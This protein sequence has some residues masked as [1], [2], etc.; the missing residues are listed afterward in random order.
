MKV[1]LL[2]RASED[3]E[4]ESDVTDQAIGTTERARSVEDKPEESEALEKPEEFA[5]LPKPA[6]VLQ[7]ENKA[8]QA[9]DDVSIPAINP[10]QIIGQDDDTFDDELVEVFAEE[11]SEVLE[12][13][14]E[15]FP[16]WRA[17]N[18]DQEALTEFRRAFHTLKGS[19]RMVGATVLGEL[20]WSIENMLNNVIG[21]SV[22]PV[23]TLLDLVE[24]VI[25][26]IPGLVADYVGR[27]QQETD[28]V[29][30]C[31]KAAEAFSD[32]LIPDMGICFDSGTPDDV[33][34]AEP[35][36]I[37]IFLKESANHLEVINDFIVQ[38]NESLGNCRITEA[39][40]RSLHTL[41]GSAAMAEIKAISTVV[42]PL[43]KMIKELL[44]ANIAADEVAVGLLTRGVLLVENGLQ[45]PQ[46]SSLDKIEG[47][48][49]L[50]LE[51][52]ENLPEL[53]NAGH[54]D[55]DAD[56]QNVQSIA[57]FLADSVDCL[58][59]A[60][61]IL[62][63]WDKNPA[64]EQVDV[65]HH[66]LLNLAGSARQIGLTVVVDLAE[67]QALAYKSAKE[68]SIAV[69]DR[70]TSVMHDAHEQLISMMDQL[71]AHQTPEP[72]V[73]MLNRIQVLLTEFA[74]ETEDKSLTDAV[75]AL[76]ESLLEA[77]H[78]D[79]EEIVLNTIAELEDLREQF[80]VTD[81][82]ESQQE[83]GQKSIADTPEPESSI[84]T[85]EDSDDELLAIFMD[86][87]RDT[88]E[89]ASRNLYDWLENTNDSFQLK[90]LQRHLH[91]LK[92]GARMAGADG[93]GELGH[94]LENLYEYLCD[95]QTAA[96]TELV[97]LLIRCH[98]VLEEMLGELRSHQD[99][100]SAEPLVK[101]IQLFREEALSET[102][103]SSQSTN[104]AESKGKET[105]NDIDPEMTAVF[106]EEARDLIDT[107]DQAILRWR[108]QPGSTEPADILMRALHTMKG[109]ARVAGLMDMGE[110]SHEF[111]VLVQSLQ[112]HLHSRDY[113]VSPEQLTELESRLDLL[114]K[115]HDTLE[116]HDQG[117]LS[118][119]VVQKPVKQSSAEIVMFPGVSAEPSTPSDYVIPHGDWVP[120][121]ARAAMTPIA[122]QFQ[123]NAIAASA[124]E[125]VKIPAELL[126]Q[127]VNLSGETSIARARIEQQVND[128]S[129]TLQEMNVTIE[130]LREQLRRLDIETE[131]Q[132]ISRHEGEVVNRPD[133]DPLEMDQYS[134]LT[135]LS[136]SLV[137]SATDLM[138][139]K[140]ALVDK[141][142]DSETLLV[143]QARINSELQE[144]L[145]RTRMLPF[146]HL[147]PRLRRIVRQVS[148]ELG[149][150]AELKVI[151]S[152]GEMDRSVME[153]MVA[154]LEHMIRN[155]ID[156]GLEKS[157]DERRAAGKP[158]TGQI[159][160]SFR[161]EGG[162]IVLTVADDG[163]GLNLQAIQEKA[164]EQG[165]LAA[166]DK[167]SD[168][169]IGRMILQ[170][171]LS[172]ASKLT[173]ISGRGVGL[174]VVSSELK[175]LGG[176]M[177]IQTTESQGTLFDIRLPFTLS[178]NRAL[179]VDLGEE[180]FAVP[181]NTLEG[182]VRIS[183]FELDAYY[184]GEVGDFEYG[185]RKYQ[186][187]YLG[188]LLQGRS[189]KL[190]GISHD[191]PVLLINNGDIS[192]ALQVD[193]IEG[194]REVVVKNLGTTICFR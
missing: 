113:V 119:E 130:R 153:R 39:L 20:A 56:E 30:A 185:G 147:L 137:E 144:G 125:M 177:D 184:S 178:I 146:S 98:Q 32:G 40:Q 101:A 4:N 22:T 170:P 150:Q 85:E 66:G 162:D 81:H 35:E 18:A 160:I 132:I 122:A 145:M 46:L 120:A 110:S 95:N 173:Q 83:T 33:A 89:N 116:E 23:P 17:N 105:G 84:A 142:R 189:P 79:D 51:I 171:G 165:L 26:M 41:K 99:G 34:V 143:Q 180:L 88:L 44:N 29:Q 135:Q 157:V 31:K 12:D 75:N 186:L 108:E 129:F 47:A 118:E 152:E 136:R 21:G 19:G 77:D 158:E 78:G 45:S 107:I 111:E 97:N 102:S 164:I 5:D 155:A 117:S 148:T 172:T 37:D 159:K 62:R 190:D 166:D 176:Q 90:E 70:F 72:A 131:A 94:E 65:L 52:E 181:L 151:H 61:E 7:P 127:L 48:E 109:G 74:A 11:A 154:P 57:L 2:I 161:R 67:Q 80:S 188:D 38:F 49:E 1:Y 58:L 8:I 100:P 140:E 73:D 174:D 54:G 167:V 50:A 121:P 96:S 71:A 114:Q 15:Y 124:P 163:T 6:R 87:A 126:E 128:F 112:Q 27:S 25:A 187:Q 3:I 28:D 60:N 134:E 16:R 24:K 9:E 192:V 63:V 13:L 68:G 92:G 64:S 76:D 169:E 123:A 139:L 59:E 168:L 179:M 104:V 14:G 69:D 182:I 138:D 191:L 156:H 93:I 36:L 42:V 193:D 91:T 82:P 183:P 115:M 194:S 10:S 141:S 55:S 175:Q 43:E 103:V 86:E 149:K 106:Q 133:F 53:I